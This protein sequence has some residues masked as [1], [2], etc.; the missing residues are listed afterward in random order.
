M[1]ILSEEFYRKSKTR[2]TNQYIETG[3]YLGDGIRNVLGRYKNI[4]SI[5]LSE[6]WFNH[7]VEQF[8][9]HKEVMMHQGDSKKILPELLSKIQ[10]PVTIFLDAHYSG[11][12][13]AFGEEETPLLK[14]LEILRDRNYNDIVIVDD[15]RLLGKKGTCGM[16]NHNIYP[17]MQYDWTDVTEEKILK[18]LGPRYK[19]LLN[20][21]GVFS[22]EKHDQMIFFV[23]GE[24]QTLVI[25]MGNARGGEQTW[26]TL[27]EN[28]L[29]PYS[30]DLALCFGES[31]D[32]SSSLYE[33]AKYIWEIPEYQN[34]RT[35]FEENC[36]GGYW[37]KTFELGKGQGLFGGVD[38]HSGSGAIIFAFRH[39]IKK[40][41]SEIIK[42]YDTIILTRSDFYYAMKHPLLS[43]EFVWVPEGED[44]HGITDRHIIFPSSLSD[45][46][47]G[48]I[49]Y[50]D[51]E[52]GF[53]FTK[54][55]CKEN[56]P[57]HFFS[58][59]EGVLLSF[60]ESIGLSKK[61]KRY[62]R[63]QFTVA[64]KNEKTRWLHPGSVPSFGNSDLLVK[65][66]QEYKQV[67]K[68]VFD[69]I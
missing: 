28:L 35:Y 57:S 1:P 10:E 58:N 51:S 24:T 9:D 34:W 4:H 22:N 20:T 26:N 15:C 40:N 2:P 56:Q 44:W 30:A 13:T 69:S 41:Y 3:A 43:N 17:T 66:I 47:L 18:A 33:R 11:D 5:E 37:E 60:F 67:L 68:T 59:P 42:K 46:V 39:F 50:M 8:K 36:F 19:R 21:N 49:E 45:D 23:P 6:K 12:F 25:L 62:P 38:N 16:P 64:R 53:E 48:I 31:T 29:E 55:F 32:R 54:K 61:I 52:S 14:E 7:N 65:Y 27:Y 63:V